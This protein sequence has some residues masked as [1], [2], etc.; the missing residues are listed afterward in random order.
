MITTRPLFFIL[1]TISI[2]IFVYLIS[3][4]I[5]NYETGGNNE[6]YF[7][8]NY[9]GYDVTCEINYFAEPT[10]C[11]VID[12]NEIQV[13]NDTLIDILSEKECYMF[14]NDNILPCRLD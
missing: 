4:H 7:V 3:D 12:D 2:V 5:I 9:H 6:E 11:K 10:N 8:K 1:I 13:P 14:E